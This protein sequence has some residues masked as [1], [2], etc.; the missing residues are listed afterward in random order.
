MSLLDSIRYRL[1][2]LSGSRQHEQELTEEMGF[3]VDAEARQREH[4]GRGT[5]SAQ[6]AHDAAR[7]RFGNSTYYREEVRRISGLDMFDTLAQDARFALRTFA[8]APVFTAVVVATLAIGIGA[9]TAIFSALDT[10]LLTPLPFRSPDRLMSVS[11]TVPATAGGQSRDDLVWSYPKIQAFRE[12]QAVFSDLTAWF[13]VQSTLR[14][15][16]DAL[17]VSGEFIDSH[18]FPTLGIIPALGRAMLPTENVVGGAP[19]VVISDELWRSAFNADSSVIGK[20]L[21]I[22]V[23]VF[24]IIGV[25]PARFAGVSGQAQFWIPFLSAPPAWDTF[26]FL[27]PKQHTFFLIGRLAPGVAPERASAIAREIG[28]RIDE[29]FPA[30]GASARHLGIAARTLDATRIDDSDR[31]TLFLLFSAVGLVLLVACVNVANLFLVRA[32]SRRREI[33][34]RLAIGASRMRVVRQLLVES[35]L[36]ALA[37]GA[38]SLAVAAIGVRVISAARPALWGTQSASGIGTVFVDAIHLNLAAFAF[39]GAIAIATGVL[40]GLAPAIQ[41][42]RPELTDSLK[43]ETGTRSAIARRL[44]TRETLTAFEIA[45]AVVLLAGSGV[46]VRSLIHLMGVRPGFEPS[47]VLTMRVNRAVAWSRDSIDRF[48]DVA[49]GRLG[50]LPGVTRVAVA[51]CVPQSGGC[52]G[53]EVTVLDRQAGAQDMAAGVHWST[54]GWTDVLRVPLLRG[55]SIEPTD[56][57]DT[58]RVAVVNQSAAR[59]FWPNDDALGKRVVLGH[60]TARVVGIVGDVRYFGIQ[61]PPR[62]DIYISYYQFPM[63]FRMMLLLRTNRDPAGVAEAAR[64]AL[65]VVAPGF[66]VYNVA[67]LETRIGGALGEARFLAQLLSLFAVLALVLATIGAYGVISYAVAQRTRELGIRIALGATRRNLMR[68]VV[69]HGAAVAAVGGLLGVAGASVAIRLIRSHLYGVEPT[70]PVTLA[71]IVILLILVVLVASWI[72]ARRAAGIP[73]VQALRGG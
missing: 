56:R 66:P 40:F 28:P 6:A 33:A 35:V 11:L 4:A 2:V 43:S 48:Y 50:S 54:P 44:S 36:L 41:A 46:L 62:P 15:G 14:V 19:V 71:G 3:F 61:E 42:T 21:G 9:N 13:G 38:A 30:Q 69:G 68:L 27:D 24:T 64:R 22:D 25:A 49:V 53:G 65:R 8:R 58:P 23:A 10:L 7:R 67:T 63:S 29:R 59:A 16:D 55:R 72:P 45:L 12:S 32:A 73:A 17:R 20:P 47:G 39:A 5:L 60:D 70:D 34:V 1:R 37:G 52:G 31:R 18:Y 57:R 51:D 26:N